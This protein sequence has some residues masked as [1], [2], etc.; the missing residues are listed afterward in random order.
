MGHVRIKICGITSS[1]D[2]ARAEALGADALGF[3]FYAPSPRYITPDAAVMILRDL[4]PFTE[5]VAVFVNED[6]VNIWEMLLGIGYVKTVQWHGE[7]PPAALER[8][9]AYVPAFPVRDA[10]SLDTVRSYLDACR[11]MDALPNAILLDGHRTGLHGG[12]GQP[13]PWHLLAQ[14][15]AGVPVILAGGLTP[16]NIA[17]AIRIVRPYAVDVAS[18]VESSPGRKD[19]EKL[20]RFIAQAREAAAKL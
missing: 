15:D 12:T 10:G 14:F 16:D 6:L 11:Q 13:T 17:E 8:R 1:A 2:A 20:R 5:P 9:Y 3:N 19:P 4:A 18:G 7:A